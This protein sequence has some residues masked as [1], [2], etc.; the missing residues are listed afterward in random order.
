M[1]LFP[2]YPREM[3]SSSEKNDKSFF[4]RHPVRIMTFRPSIHL[5]NRIASMQRLLHCS[6][7]ARIGML[8][9]SFLFAAATS[10]AA[11]DGVRLASIDRDKV[12]SIKQ[13]LPAPIVTEKNEYYEVRGNN[14]KEL[15]CQLTKN[16]CVWRDGERFDSVTSWHIT[17]DYGYRHT[18]EGYKADAFTPHSLRS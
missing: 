18:P 13:A 7:T 17:W 6:G 12:F 2:L 11:K 5:Q 8:V 10:S 16:G 14:E 3:H 9:L 1:D 4:S 15:K